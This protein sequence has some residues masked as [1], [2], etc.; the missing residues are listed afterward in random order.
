MLRLP[1]TSISLSQGDVAFAEQQLDIYLGLLKQGFKKRDILRYFEA[2]KPAANSAAQP[3]EDLRAP[4][5]VDLITQ[6]REC[7]AVV[8]HVLP[9]HPDDAKLH[10]QQHAAEGAEE[11]SSQPLDVSSPAQSPHQSQRHAPRQSSML[12]FGQNASPT[13]FDESQITNSEFRPPVR[14]YRPRTDTYSYNQS[15]ISESDLIQGAA[16]LTVDQTRVSTMRPEAEDFVPANRRALGTVRQPC[17]S[18]SAVS[19][20]RASVGSN[21]SS[22]SSTT[23]PKPTRPSR[24]IDD[25]SSSEGNDENSLS[26][27]SVPNTPVRRRPTPCHSLRNRVLDGT[28]PF[29]VYNDAALGD[30]QPQSPADLARQPILNEHNAAYTAPVGMIHSPTRHIRN[31]REGM[32][33]EG[34][35]TPTTRAITMQNRRAR[36]LERS[37][38]LE[39]VRMVR[40]RTVD[41]ATTGGAMNVQGRGAPGLGGGIR[42]ERVSDGNETDATLITGVTDWRDSLEEDRVGEE[43][44]E[45][46]GAAGR[47]DND[48]GMRVLSGNARAFRD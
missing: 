46:E 6:A 12:R 43:N 8:G 37:V 41:Q 40:Q 26:L 1:P 48:I 19:S 10:G 15:E 39:A 44:W 42:E 34:S 22:D 25:S 7:R 3:N 18:E 23:P 17:G 21:D 11:Q 27:L 20:I 32:S 47:D 16:A 5:T 35:Q 28:L 4:S 14:T 36:E 33:E 13:R 2:Q 29:Y 9:L 24:S 45:L 30:I 31:Q 38:R